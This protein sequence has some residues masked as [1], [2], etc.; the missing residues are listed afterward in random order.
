[1][2]VKPPLYCVVDIYIFIIA[3][4]LIKIILNNSKT[5]FYLYAAL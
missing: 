1:M 2:V 4:S 5:K 3:I